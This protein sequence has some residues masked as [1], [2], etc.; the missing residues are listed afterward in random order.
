MIFK[1]RWRRWAL[2]MML[3]AVVSVTALT[4]STHQSISAAPDDLESLVAPIER[5]I[6]LDRNSARLNLSYENIWNVQDRIA[7]HDLSPLLVQAF[8]VAEDQRFLNHRGVDWIARFNALW[9]N[10]RAAKIVR[11]ASTITEQV[12]RIIHPRQ[13]TVWSRWLEGFEAMALEERFNKHEVLEF[14]LNQIPY[15]ARKRGIVQA[16]RYYFDRDLA[17]LNEKEM[18]ALAVLIRSPRWLDPVGQPNNLNRAILTLAERLQ[19]LTFLEL[20]PRVVLA[21]SLSKPND[22]RRF[23]TQ[24]FVRFADQR[25]RSRLPQAQILPTTLDGDLQHAAQRLLDTRLASLAARNVSNGAVLI[26]DHETN[27]IRSWVV[28]FAGRPD[29]GSNQI[30]TVLAKRQPG[31]ALKP[32][33]YTQALMTGWS[34]AMMLDDS[35]LEQ[36]VGF[37]LHAYHN[38]SRNHYGLISLR[39]AL[40]NS[41]NIP[42]V[43]TLQSVGTKNFLGFLGRLGIKSLAAHP[44]QYGDGLALGNG[45]LSLYELVQA[46][47]VIARMG[48]FKP[49]SIFENEYLE[50]HSRRIFSEDVASVIAHIL[51]DPGAREKEFGRN[52]VLNF[53]TPTAVKT[54]TSSDYRDAWA[55]GFNDKFTVGVWMG[56]LDYTKMREVTGSRGPALVLRSVFTELNRNRDVRPLFLSPQLIAQTVCINSGVRA[57]SNCETRHEWFVP[58]TGPSRISS[59]Q[60][61]VRLRR[62]SRGLALAL[63]PRIPDD[64]EFFEFCVS[65]IDDLSRVEWFVNDRRV[66]SSTTRSFAWKLARGEFKVRAHVY[67]ASLAKPVVTETVPYRVN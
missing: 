53:S 22:S 63:D 66:G 14:Y 25:A 37:G 9:S 51:A 57:H 44:N 15:G 29:H 33:L 18:L 62:P 3:A 24:H 45:E 59:I 27:E 11:G 13:R 35:P 43:K 42:A 7:L 16:A 30:D 40:G 10:L 5:N 46:Y 54:G 28:G 55:L 20:E 61:N 50:N 64:K 36:A 2:G 21:E 65:E 1:S 19:Q 6:F 17:T 41:L 34:A 31:S 52:S 23:N 56:N 48:D 49:L 38:Y 12:A 8:I 26:V 67:L 58:G 47:T 60:K 4:L 32:F 39:E